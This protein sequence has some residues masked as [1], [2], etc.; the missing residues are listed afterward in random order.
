MPEADKTK[1]RCQPLLDGLATGCVTAAILA[2]CLWAP[3][4]KTMGEAQRIVYVHVAVAWFALVGLL[5]MAATGLMYLRTRKLDWDHWSQSAAELGWLA[6]SLTLLT[7][8]LWAHQ[9]WGT[10][11]TW[12][13]RLSTAFIL[14]AIYSGCLIV[15]ASLDEPHRRARLGAVLGILGICDVPLVVVAAHWFR[16][17]HPSSPE[18]EPSM[19]GVLLLSVVGFSAVLALLLVRRHG[20]LRLESLLA[21]MEQTADSDAWHPAANGDGA[22][23]PS[24]SRSQ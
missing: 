17:I 6:C 23:F 13:P 10:W 5:I 4:E 3:R 7:G 12:D 20:Q 2:I 8:S 21:A 11:W 9:A 14:W 15:R 18:M 1:P 19:R 24:N 22:R 16:G